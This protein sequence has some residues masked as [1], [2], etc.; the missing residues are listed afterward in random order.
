[1][2][3]GEKAAMDIYKRLS[4]EAHKYSLVID[5]LQEE[6][7]KV[8]PDSTNTF[9]AP[10]KEDKK[11][12]K[13]L[14]QIKNEKV[15]IQRA[16]EDLYFNRVE[17]ELEL[18]QDGSAKELAQ[19]ELNFR[20]KIT[21]INRQEE[22]LLQVLRNH[23]KKEWEAKGGQGSF[24]ENSI[25]LPKEQAD[26]FERM[27][28][29]ESKAYEN[30][31]DDV[32][33]KLLLKYQTYAERRKSIEE[34]FQKDIAELSTKFGADSSAV[35]VA[36]EQMKEAL[37]E[38][39]EEVLKDGGSGLL[40]LYLFGDGADFLTSKIKEAL[41]LFEDITKLTF[42]ELSKV[43]EII[44]K[45]TFTDKQLALFKEAG[46]DVDKLKTALDEAKESAEGMLDAKAWEKVVEMARKLTDSLG[47]LGDSL[48]T[49]PGVVGEIGKVI[50]GL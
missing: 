19:L 46:I 39:S 44:G 6:M 42:K 28:D 30:S 38:L 37:Q 48:A 20:R 4:D 3:A 34:K 5:K 14:D 10:E 21:E 13:L 7:L 22:E 35:K 9:T 1:M 11:T 16:K 43:K 32:Y 41:P 17:A 23:A 8:S 12:A 29:A 18:L 31:Q 25:S 15:E 24:N 45:V 50:S 33:K 40:D 27:R 47:E 26:E 36:T 49:I 2:F